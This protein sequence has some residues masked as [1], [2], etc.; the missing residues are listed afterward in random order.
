MIRISGHNILLAVSWDEGT[1]TTGLIFGGASSWSILVFGTPIWLG[2]PALFPNG[3]SNGW[4]LS[5]VEAD[6]EGRY[7]PFGEI[8]V[9]AIVGNDDRAYH[10]TTELLQALN[11]VGW[12]ILRWRSAIGSVR[13]CTRRT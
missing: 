7:P 12:T 11:D 10:V 2:H 8:A 1:A 5:W 13:R 6:E 4:T 9:A 3:C